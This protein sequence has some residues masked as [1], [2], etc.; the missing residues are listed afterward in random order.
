LVSL[1][2][3]TIVAVSAG[4]V[5]VVLGWI[6]RSLMSRRPSG[7]PTSASFAPAASKALGVTPPEASP[8][9]PPAGIP[10]TPSATP[11]EAPPTLWSH[12]QTPAPVRVADGTAGIG[13]AARVI[14]HLSRLGRLGPDDLAKVGSTQQGIALAL[15]VSQGSLVR[16]LQRLVAGEMLTVER[17]HVAN[18]NR[19]LKVYCLTG[20]GE[21]AARDLRHRPIESLGAKS[22]EAW[23]TPVLPTD[24]SGRERDRLGA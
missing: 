19:R 2:L 15:G 9:P 17:R 10:T 11:V 20:R 21:S 4:A 23:S 7:D 16:V 12:P 14:L 3:V 5:G 13:L 24:R 6:A 8:L 18:V 22:R 1:G